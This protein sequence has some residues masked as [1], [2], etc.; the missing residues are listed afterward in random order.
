M[1]NPIQNPILRRVLVTGIGIVTALGK[2]KQENWQNLLSGKSAIANQLLDVENP[3][4]SYFPMAR[5]QESILPS[6]SFFPRVELWLKQAVSE[7]LIDAQLETPLPDCGVVVGSSRGYQAELE[8]ILNQKSSR[9]FNQHSLPIFPYIFPGFLSQAIATQIQTNSVTLAP[10]AACATGNW[11][12]A[13][14]YELIQMQK[15]EMV[16]VGASD[17]VLTTLGMAGFKQ[18]GALAKTGLYP[19]SLERE[20]LILGE[21][22]AVLIL[23]SENSWRSRSHPR[24]YGEILGFGI[25]NDASHPTNPS[26]EGAEL[27]IL[28]CLQS[29]RRSNCQVDLVCAHGTGTLINDRMEASLIQKLFPNQPITIATKGATGHI[30]GAT[31]LIEAAFSL[32]ALSEQQI[33]P[34]IGLRTLE[35]DLNLSEVAQK[36]KLQTTLNFSFGFGGQNVII[37]LGAMD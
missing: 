26:N 7:A 32:I 9:R 30:L 3:E 10:M 15:C 24:V 12:I 23:E 4:S 27:A 19:F 29:A 6:F 35:F 28:N 5:I 21:G 33:P 8:T 22:A 16:L 2:N 20:G 25:T 17:A 18:I 34:T 1:L 14:A 11:A 37:A 31:A 36:I 13:Q